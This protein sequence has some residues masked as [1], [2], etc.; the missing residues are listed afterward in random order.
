[1]ADADNES[2]GQGYCSAFAKLFA[3]CDTCTM[4]NEASIRAAGAARWRTSFI[5]PLYESYCFAH[6]PTAIYHALT[7]EGP[8]G[9]PADVFGDLPQRYDVVVLFFV[10]AFGWRYFEK[11]ADRYPLLQH[12]VRHGVV[13]KLTAQ[14]PSTTTAHVTCVHT[15]LPPAQSGVYEWFQYHP[16]VDRIIAP[17]L[18]SFAGDKAR[19]T[20]TRAGLKP[21]DVFPADTLYQ[22]LS[23]AGVKSYLFH[24]RDIADGAPARALTESAE[25][26]SYKTLPEILVNLRHA[27][28]ARKGPA[29]FLLYYSAIDSIGHEYGPTSEH[30]EAELDQFCITVER[31]F[32]DPLRANGVLFIVTADH[33][34]V[35]VN[36]KTTIYLNHALPRFREYIA[37]NRNGDLLTPAGSPRDFF[38][39]V[40]PE[41][42]DEAQAAVA[43]CL[44]GRALVMKTAE[45]IS[46]G[47]FGPSP[48]ARFLECVGNLVVLPFKGE[49]VYYYEREKFENRFCGHHGGLTPEEMEIPLLMCAL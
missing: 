30:I 34:M 14:F 23:R 13:S 38:L 39:H 25:L 47:F 21:T 33:G 32:L 9:W 44:N 2:H 31:L 15:G 7:G 11:I 19:D 49:S 4:L 12:F 24:T 41:R 8:L 16:G 27:L 48:T 26:F 22:R 28:D 40:R 5:R 42:L 43:E 29:Y 1:M 36:P 37:A 45:L 3:A 6:L 17:L 46:E 18:F 20:L 35:E 10:D